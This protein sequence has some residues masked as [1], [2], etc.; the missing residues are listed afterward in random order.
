MCEANGVSP[1]VPQDRSFQCGVSPAPPPPQHTQCYLEGHFRARHDPITRPSE[2][3]CGFS[4][5]KALH[6]QSTELKIPSGTQASTH[7]QTEAHG[8]RWLANT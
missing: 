6:I 5:Y 2:M 7:Q 4:L 8:G 1:G 3:V